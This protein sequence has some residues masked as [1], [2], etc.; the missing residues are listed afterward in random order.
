MFLD[1]IL[2]IGNFIFESFRHIWPYLVVTI[3]L[4]VA[5]QM[6][7]ASKYIKRAFAAKPFTAI[8]LATAVGAFSPFCSCGVISVI[9]SLLISGVPLAPV[10]SFWIASPSMDPEIF[11]LSVGMIGWELAV[12]RLVATLFL[13]FGAGLITHFVMVKGW[14]G[15]PILRSRKSTPVQSTFEL[16]KKGWN[17]LKTRVRESPPAKHPVVPVGSPSDTLLQLVSVLQPSS[18]VISPAGAPLCESCSSEAAVSPVRQ[19]PS[20]V[21]FSTASNEACRN[22]QPV[23]SAGCDNATSF[24]RRLFK[25]T[26]SATWMVGKFMAL[27]FI[28]EA[29]I[30][31]YVPAS[32]IAGSLGSQ[33]PMAIFTA[34]LLGVPAYTTSLT[35]LPMI[36]GLLAQGMNPAAALAFLIAGPIT[37][38]PAMAAV[39]PL[40]SRRIFVPYVSFALVGAV[41]AGLCYRLAASG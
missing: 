19:F 28:L 40:V 36:S 20:A 18:F 33:S 38:L 32:W 9:A 17:Q 5:I 30:T 2:K 4:A 13:S 8:I 16:I 10:M 3:P 24:K 7:G 41:L 1:E 12:W 11:F 15:Q 29:L 34:A 31:L 35:A 14:L 23:E 37:T 21:N 25:E 26:L 6:S 22:S 39:W 27:A